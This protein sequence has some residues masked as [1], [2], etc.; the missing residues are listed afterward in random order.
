MHFAFDEIEASNASELYVDE[1]SYPMRTL[2]A[3]ADK[4]FHGSLHVCRDGKG[5][6]GAGGGQSQSAAIRKNARPIMENMVDFPARVGGH[7]IFP[8][9]Q[10]ETVF[11][12]Y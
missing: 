1:R 8:Y 5:W 12:Q 6:W 7:R 4:F 2:V 3:V 11:W 9:A 10:F